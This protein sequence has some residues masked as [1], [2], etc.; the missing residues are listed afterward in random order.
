MFATGEEKRLFTGDSKLTDSPEI[1][2]LK[3]L[4]LNL[5][6]HV[7]KCMDCLIC[8]DVVTASHSTGVLE[9]LLHLSNDKKTKNKVTEQC[10]VKS[11]N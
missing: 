1:N 6:C 11:F 3:T 4:P 2:T 9:L 10:K 5:R 8:Q 7:T